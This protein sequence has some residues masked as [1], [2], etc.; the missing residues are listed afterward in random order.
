[1]SSAKP[2][3]WHGD[4]GHAT[5]MLQHLL[6]RLDRKLFPELPNEVTTPEMALGGAD[7]AISYIRHKIIKDTL[8][9]GPPRS[10]KAFLAANTMSQSQA[11]DIT[12]KEGYVAPVYDAEHKRIVVSD[13]RRLAIVTDPKAMTAATATD[14]YVKKYIQVIPY[15]A[16]VDLASTDFLTFQIRELTTDGMV[17]LS[18]YDKPSVKIVYNANYLIQAAPVMQR[19]EDIP[20][21]IEPT[22]RIWVSPSNYNVNITTPTMVRGKHGL[23]LLMPMRR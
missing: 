21:I 17:I 23:T 6:H 18:R 2:Q 9:D 13:G 4:A 12:D 7:L 22:L 20:G 15:G 19:I 14:D 16:P 11:A 5:K 1:M 3:P 10:V 8:I